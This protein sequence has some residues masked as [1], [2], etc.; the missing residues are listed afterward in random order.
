MHALRCSSLCFHSIELF[1]VLIIYF[2]NKI[3][4]IELTLSVW[5]PSYLSRLSDVQL[6]RPRKNFMV[7]VVSN[8]ERS[9][10]HNS[11]I[12]KSQQKYLENLEKKIIC[13]TGRLSIYQHILWMFVSVG[14]LHVRICVLRCV[15]FVCLFLLLRFLALTKKCFL[16]NQ[17]KKINKF[18]LKITKGRPIN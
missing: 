12:I 7:D 10:L 18:K 2:Q 17:Q 16:N 1:S 5:L 14:T 6:A 8:T 15:V 4:C 11:Q 13:I 9:W 3:H